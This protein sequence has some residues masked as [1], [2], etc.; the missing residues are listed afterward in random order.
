MLRQILSR[1]VLPSNKMDIPTLLGR[2]VLAM[3]ENFCLVP[4][5]FGYQKEE[6]GVQKVPEALGGWKGWIIPTCFF[7]PWSPPPFLL[8]L[9]RWRFSQLHGE[10]FISLKKGKG[11][12]EMEVRGKESSGGRGVKFTTLL[13]IIIIKYCNIKLVWIM[14]YKQVFPI[15]PSK[16]R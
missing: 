5:V 2:E 4:Q 13:I 9:L 1:S 12:R 15:F 3:E 11:I 14:V 6:A 16:L 8:D 10:Y 7:R